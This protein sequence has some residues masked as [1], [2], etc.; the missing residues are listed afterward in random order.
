M[1][2]S[3]PSMTAI[4]GGADWHGGYGLV[5]HVHKLLH[6][7]EVVRTRCFWRGLHKLDRFLEE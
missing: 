4:V 5:G 6:I 3:K 2:F 7:W 1:G